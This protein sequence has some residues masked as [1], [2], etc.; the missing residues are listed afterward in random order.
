MNGTMYGPETGRFIQADPRLK[1][2][3][4]VMKNRAFGASFDDH[5]RTTLVRCAEGSVESD[6]ALR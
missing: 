3:P 6:D 1:P 2:N 5:W 4:Q